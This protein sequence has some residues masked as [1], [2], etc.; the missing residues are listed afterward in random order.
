MFAIWTFAVTLVAV[1]VVGAQ[2]PPSAASVV[3]AGVIAGRVTDAKSGA[4]LGYCNVALESTPRGAVADARG[5]FIISNVPAG[6]YAL[7]VSR[8]GHATQRK[9]DVLVSPG[10]TTRVDIALQSVLIEADPVVVTA[11]RVEQT[12][13]MAP[14]SVSV[15]SQDEIAARDPST[16]DRAIET[17]PGLNAFRSTGGI[18]VQSIQIRGSSDVAGGGV[19]NRVLLL[20]DGRP[21][22]TPD[23]GGALWA[24]VPVQFIDHV[25]VVKGAF[26]SLYGS[27]AM[28]GVVNVITRRPGPVA[29]GKVE[30]KL[31]FYEQPTSDLRYT[32]ETPLQNG[33]S[34]DYAT[35]VGSTSF[36]LGASRNESDGYAENTAFTFYDVYGKVLWNVNDE[37]TVEL[38]LGGGQAENDYPHSWLSSGDPLEVRASYEDDYQEK[39]YANADLLYW[40]FSGENLKYSMRAYYYHLVQQS[41]FNEDDPNLDIPGNEPFGQVTDINGDKLGNL[42][43]LD[44][45]LGPR[46]RIVSGIDYQLDNVVSSP[47]SILYGDH[48]INNYAV[49]A[50]DDVLLARTLTA[51]AGARY[52]WNHLVGGRTLEQLSPKLALVWATTPTLSLRALYG[53]AFRAPTIAEMFTER[54]IGGG[55]DFVPN[56]DLDAERLVA[57]FE[58][59]VHW[60][61]RPVF[62]LD[63]AGFR[64]EYED[65]MYFADVSQ[66]VGV[67]F[68]YQVRNLT[69]A[70]MQGVEATVQ[71]QWRSVSA[72]ANYTYLDARD[73]SPGRTDDILAYRPEHSGAL[74]AD[75]E[76]D[77]WTVHG[78]GRYR[79]QIDEVFLYPLQAP[80]AFW[81][82]NGAAQCEVNGAWMFSVKVNNVLDASYEEIA[83]YRMPGRNWMFGV[84]MRF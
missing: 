17:V 72:F 59:G 3:G 70:L 24:L 84:T 55:I 38:T 19:G 61:P 27:T 40:G 76:W 57:S 79:S 13:R 41:F 77:R 30:M 7:V 11:T 47:D 12:A 50:Q 32:S 34:A 25:E 21:A 16:F 66:E 2:S 49:F 48:Q 51:T 29:T 15:L 52:D 78:D 58:A 74:G 43:T 81:V 71:S 45:R 65:L 67:P 69:S 54:E 23:S 80:E 5:R 64:Y 18:S 83:R 28:G 14:A 6:T 37:R 46:N 1:T 9:S 82:F 42:V 36:L 44:A 22:L 10:D 26:S 35:Q 20:V 31:G 53:Q 73:E 62:G 63:V 8:V 75:V 39:A 56:P 33:I 68:A 60:N 4:V